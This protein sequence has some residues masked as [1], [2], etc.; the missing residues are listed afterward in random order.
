MPFCVG[1][2]GDAETGRV[3]SEVHAQQPLSKELACKG[4]SQALSGGAD[5]A[6]FYVVGAPVNMSS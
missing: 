5:L 6:R 3:Q 2:R 4:L 1:A